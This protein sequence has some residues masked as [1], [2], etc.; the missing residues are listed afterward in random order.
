[1]KKLT[2][3][4]AFVLTVA[5]LVGMMPAIVLA[6]NSQARAATYAP[7]TGS[8][9]GASNVAVAKYKANYYDNWYAIYDK[10][11]FAKNAIP[12]AN[13]AYY[14]RHLVSATYDDRNLYITYPEIGGTSNMWLTSI[15]GQT[16]PVNNTTV[17]GY[18]PTFTANTPENEQ[19]LVTAIF[20]FNDIGIELTDFNQVYRMTFLW[21]GNTKWFQQEVYVKFAANNVAVESNAALNF[22]SANK[23]AVDV[24]A[25]ELPNVVNAGNK[26][27]LEA[28]FVTVIETNVTLN[29]LPLDSAWVSNTSDI[30][31]TTDGSGKATNPQFA[32]GITFHYRD[33]NSN[34]Y[35]GSFGFGIA[36]NSDTGNLALIT[37]FAGNRKS[38]YDIT[39]K[40]PNT[41][42]SDD[43]SVQL[44]IRAEINYKT[45]VQ[46]WQ[47]V[48]Q[49]SA[50]I[51]YYING[52]YIMEK[53]LSD[54]LMFWHSEF[55]KNKLYIEAVDTANSGIDVTVNSYSVSYD[56]TKNNVLDGYLTE[57]TV[58]GSNTSADALTTNLNLA[59]TLNCPIT[60]G[61]PI[62]WV[63]LT[64]VAAN[65]AVNCSKN[66]TASV[67][68]KLAT[69]ETKTLNFKVAPS[70]HVPGEA[71][72]CGA[73]SCTVCGGVATEPTGAHAYTECVADPA[74][75]KSTATPAAKAVYYKTCKCGAMSTTETFEH[76]EPLA[77]IPDDGWDVYIHELKNG[78]A[79]DGKV[80]DGFKLHGALKDGD[81]N[82]L[83]FGMAWNSKYIYL[84]YEKG[85]G[86]TAPELTKLV[87]NGRTLDVASLA[88]YTD[89][90]V[91]VVIPLTAANINLAAYNQ[92]YAVKMVIGDYFGGGDI[93]LTQGLGG[94]LVDGDG[95]PI[96][97]SPVGST[98]TP[99]ANTNTV[100]TKN[101]DGTYSF[102]IYETVD[103]AA[104]P[105]A[106][107]YDSTASVAIGTTPTILDFTFTPSVLPTFTIS[108]ATWGWYN[109]W[110]NYYK[111]TITEDINAGKF[112]EG[113]PDAGKE[114]Q[115]GYIIGIG[116]HQSAADAVPY[117]YFIVGV[118]DGIKEASASPA[119]YI[120][121]GIP[122]TST[123]TMDI[124][125]VYDNSN[126]YVNSYTDFS[127]VPAKFFV[128]GQLVG[129]MANIRAFGVGTG[130][131][132]RLLIQS[133]SNFAIDATFGNIG[134][135][136]ANS[137]VDY[138]FHEFTEEVATEEHIKTPATPISVAVYYKSCS[139]CGE[140]D[141]LRSETFNGTELGT[142]FPE[143]DDLYIYETN[144]PMVVDGKADAGFKL[145]GILDNTAG[146]TRPFGV[147][148][149]DEYLYIA[150]AGT[151]LPS[152]LIINGVTVDVSTVS[153]A[154]DTH[155]EIAIPMED[156]NIA[157][158]AYNVPVEF[159]ILVD[160]HLYGGKVILSQSMG[161][162]I[163]DKDNSPLGVNHSSTKPIENTVT[164]VTKDENGIYTFRFAKLQNQVSVLDTV[165]FQ[166]V[167]ALNTSVC[168]ATVIDFTLTPTDIPLSTAYR[169]TAGTYYWDQ[170]VGIRIS[171]D[172][173]E[174]NWAAGAAAS[175]QKQT[176]ILMG[177]V[178]DT[179]TYKLLVQVNKSTVATTNTSGTVV[180]DTKIPS[181]STAPMDWRIVYENT[182]ST[183]N[184][185]IDYTKIPA[186]IYL[187]G[188]LIA[189]LD[190]VR[191]FGIGTGNT[192]SLLI[193]P[194]TRY[195]F[196]VDQM[197]TFDIT[198]SNIGATSLA[199]CYHRFV[200]EVAEDKYLK[201]PASPI[202]KA[203]YWKSCVCG[204]M[205]TTETFEHGEISSVYPNLGDLYAGQLKTE[206]ALD[207]KI[208]EK[209]FFITGA[210]LGGN[211]E[212][213][214]FGVV[215]T[216][217]AVYIAYKKPATGDLVVRF[218]NK[219]ITIPAANKF[220]GAGDYVEIKVPIS[221]TG[222]DGKT[223]EA[224]TDFVL[225][226][227]DIFWSGKLIFSY[228]RFYKTPSSGG[229]VA[230]L[231]P[232]EEHEVPENTIREVVLNENGT[233]TFRLAKTKDGVDTIAACY[234]R[235]IDQL[236][237]G[238]RAT[239]VD[240]SL[241]PTKLMTSN[242][243][244]PT[245]YRYH[246][247]EFVEI[248]VAD[249]TNASTFADGTPC[250]GKTL[251]TGFV[252]GVANVDGT[253]QFFVQINKST[254]PTS[255][256]MGTEYY[257]TGIPA[258][259]GEEIDVKIICDITEEGSVKSYTEYSK[260]PVKVFING[261]LAFD[262][263]DGRSFGIGT[264]G[265]SQVMMSLNRRWGYPA[266]NMKASDVTFS[267]VS[268][269]FAP[270][271]INDTS[272]DEI[273][274]AGG[275]NPVTGDNTPLE[276]Y[277]AVLVICMLGMG[278]LAI[279]LLRKKKA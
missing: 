91:E 121:T 65:G 257:D 127:P 71:A 13:D 134:M 40:V 187:N 167:G 50:T 262:L 235:E 116:K 95:N 97:P 188:A 260:I 113:S 140:H 271:D 149:D 209:D 193:A 94:N 23:V 30:N 132:S 266:E 60:G 249:D 8:I 53:G 107:S 44:N 158:T 67:T 237:S 274:G 178:K 198:V 139:H 243:V 56:T 72:P 25:I 232:G 242:K 156:L 245:Q 9:S 265:G 82:A 83:P 69:G 228:P 41:Q 183:V 179:D 231:G 27:T 15:S 197:K 218:N 142:V 147:S 81:G 272:V 38:F 173:N 120:N 98:A 133:F 138:C 126:S 169:T 114:M 68:A 175:G 78:I 216:T 49:Y 108:Q 258:T 200:N 238:N 215:W 157:I 32:E 146:S 109:N 233:Y 207:G 163:V 239:I 230:K 276:L 166:G 199:D 220:D 196:A 51:K 150:Y 206:V 244:L 210:M 89:T 223:Y 155:V 278:A 171:D 34:W 250:E 174:S 29:Q 204:A 255:L 253:V 236:V 211:G 168:N 214:P 90:H 222:F 135:S 141:E 4:T 63:D 86:A 24:P 182:D 256:V 224:Q 52:Q 194:S 36:R 76:G 159:D 17:N 2:K 263:E 101:A 39:A 273:P 144:K 279:P 112:P 57:E 22:T 270:T 186:K 19:R 55:G 14:N 136:Y 16:A 208:G 48:Q 3:L 47:N 170:Y 105:P 267:N 80:D 31:F 181:T 264:G 234:F 100:V 241:K 177:I 92:K 189:S 180:V 122:V 128:N 99:P 35:R 110:N 226:V 28:P 277:V 117:I 268:V 70:V 84:V 261:V 246:W 73:S 118:H 213:I 201:D 195:G 190:D 229:S 106:A 164:E 37:L 96:V 148:W 137:Y 10:V 102:R 269:T 103:G 172:K 54:S 45:T 125:V 93:L 6:D 160:G 219:D 74:Y 251:Q 123:D 12:A 1:M 62:S 129:E 79:L 153:K 247:G 21:R 162:V 275:N 20:P 152:T 161:S 26:P 252:M 165:Y 254:E 212:E 46:D 176:G 130:G 18:N 7:H 191:S 11:P 227:G 85:T 64:N 221:E 124:R 225:R 131:A 61:M 77:D 151:A 111:L 5:M 143:Y 58:L 119:T 115:T 240:F 104:I 217:E 202:A 33:N 259:S 184:S 145:H 154:V 87:I 75:L 192:S 66:M 42:L 203:V 205:S 248:F 59:T 43:G 88:K 185:Y